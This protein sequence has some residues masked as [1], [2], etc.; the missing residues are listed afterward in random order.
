M[1]KDDLVRFDPTAGVVL[2]L[3]FFKGLVGGIQTGLAL[4]G[5]FGAVICHIGFQSSRPCFS[6]SG[7]A[8]FTDNFIV[9]T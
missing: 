3:W 7:L 4:V 2:W 1:A 5:L 6:L 8:D 9:S